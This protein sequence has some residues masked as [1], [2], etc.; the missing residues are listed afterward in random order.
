MGSGRTVTLVLTQTVSSDEGVL[1]FLLLA[2]LKVDGFEDHG[3]VVG[4]EFHSDLGMASE[5]RL[6]CHDAREVV[7]TLVFDGDL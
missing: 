6:P 2:L 4:W 7:D 3:T 5:R 1:P